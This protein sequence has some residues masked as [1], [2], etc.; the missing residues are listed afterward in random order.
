MARYC[1]IPTRLRQMQMFTSLHEIK[2]LR[3]DE[4]AR[5]RTLLA[6]LRHTECAYYY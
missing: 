3:H 4:R 2:V 6:E 5:S 1:S